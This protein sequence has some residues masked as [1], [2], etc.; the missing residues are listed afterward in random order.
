MY[1]EVINIFSFIILYANL[2]DLLLHIIVIYTSAIIDILSVHQ[3]C[4]TIKSEIIIVKL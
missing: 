4:W 1:I 3:N 2:I